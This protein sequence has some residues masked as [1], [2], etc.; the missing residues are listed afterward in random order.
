MSDQNEKT[1][2][3]RREGAIRWLVNVTGATEANA[4]ETV[5]LLESDDPVDAAALA[6]GLNEVMER[7]ASNGSSTEVTE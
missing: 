5:R 3:T 7:L 4:R 6:D 1:P 2:T